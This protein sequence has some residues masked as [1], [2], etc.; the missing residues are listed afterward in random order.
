MN[1]TQLKKRIR[2]FRY[3]HNEAA[4]KHGMQ[5][6]FGSAVMFRRPPKGYAFTSPKLLKILLKKMRVDGV[7]QSN[8]S[9]L[10]TRL[11]EWDL[12]GFVI[13]KKYL[14]TE[15]FDFDRYRADEG[16]KRCIASYIEA[17]GIEPNSLRLEPTR[18]D[19]VDGYTEDDGSAGSSVNLL[20]RIEEGSRKLTAREVNTTSRE[21]LPN[22]S[23][24]NR[25]RNFW[26]VDRELL[27]E[28][29]QLINVHTR[30]YIVDKFDC[31]DFTAS[32]KVRLVE[33]GITAIGEVSDY[34]AGHAYIAAVI[35]HQDPEDDDDLD[36][37]V[38]E[39]QSGKEVET[40]RGN[41]LALKG[42]VR[43]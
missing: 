21:L 18:R 32:L 37:A 40:G 12:R 2:K 43:W 5:K 16:D 25:D 14:I 13:T 23:T 7:N 24:H 26:A 19:M 11:R 31:D 3:G 4:I 39:P 28:A 33:Y 41:F 34:S 29:I 6:A 38:I 20:I 22:M 30:K 27:F 35:A 42:E 15:T 1:K 8:V 36:I 9:V 17:W 10:R